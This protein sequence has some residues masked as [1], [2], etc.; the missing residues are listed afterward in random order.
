MY[1]LKIEINCIP[2]I[3]DQRIKQRIRS[4][5]CE[6][7]DVM[8]VR[9]LQLTG[10][11]GLGNI[12]PVGFVPGRFN[13]SSS[14]CPFRDHPLLNSTTIHNTGLPTKD[15][16]VQ[17]KQLPETVNFLCLINLYHIKI[18][19][20]LGNIRLKEFQV[21]FTVFS[22]ELK[23]TVHCYIKY[24]LALCKRYLQLSFKQKWQ[25]P[26]HNDTLYLINNMEDVDIYLD[27][28]VFNSDNF[29]V[30][31]QRNAQAAFIQKI[32]SFQ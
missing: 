19:F 31:L 9:E 27:L 21:I 3:I 7:Q 28:R 22:F 2:F 12:C 4:I 32:V 8:N 29:N 15:E 14:H 30:F 20:N 25:C 23:G 11:I 1:F 17:N 10:T 24:S 6:C 5:F 16:I 13:Y 26:I 18:I